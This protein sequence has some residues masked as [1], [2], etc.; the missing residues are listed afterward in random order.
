MVVE[1]MGHE[2]GVDPRSGGG[3]AG[4]KLGTTR[5]DLSDYIRRMRR[6]MRLYRSFS[7]RST[8]NRVS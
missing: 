6:P 3:E 2:V 7:G 5:S 8:E 4:E 1:K